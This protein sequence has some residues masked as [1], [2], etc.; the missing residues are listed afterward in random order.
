MVLNINGT[1]YE[2]KFGIRFVRELDKRYFTTGQNGYKFGIGVEIKI[3]MLLTGDVVTLAEFIHLG[4]VS[5]KKRPSV[6][7]IDE[8]VDNA[9]DIET[10]FDEVI[11]E[12]KKQ[13]ATKMK[14][15]EFERVLKAET[16]AMKNMTT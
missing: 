5:E 8:F 3:P 6:Q 16:E 10:I 1:D 14:M 15:V 13:N 12:L 9:E 11:E 7:E 2:L 4:T